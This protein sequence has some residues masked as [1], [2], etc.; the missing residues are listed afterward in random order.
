[1]ANFGIITISHKR[2]DVLRLWCASIRRL[3]KDC[4]Y[5][6][7]VVIGDEP[8]GDVVDEDIFFEPMPNNPIEAK[9]NRAMAIM[10]FTWNVDYVMISGSDDIISTP[11]L[12]DF[13]RLMDDDYD[14][15]SINKVWF[16]SANGLYKGRARGIGQSY[17]FGVCKTIHRRVIE[18]AMPLWKMERG[19]SMDA[20]CTKSIKPYVKTTA[21]AEGIVFDIKTGENMNKYPMVIR[22][23]TSEKSWPFEVD[24]NLIWSIL[25]EEE[26]LKSL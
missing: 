21:T 5:F 7:V 17:P 16:Y 12:K 13:I 23:A 4:G 25:G 20:D 19:Y 10:N 22:K 14:M 2:P 3:R 6:P 8:H 26:I 18:Q 15:I 11:L 9:W 1:M 24:S